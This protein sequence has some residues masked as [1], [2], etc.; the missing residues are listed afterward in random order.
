MSDPN[1]EFHA[2]P[3]PPIQTEP[4]RQRPTWLMWTGIALFVIGLLIVGLGL[5]GVLPGMA[6][7]GGSV[8]ALGILFFAFSFMRLP[9]IP[10]APPRMSTVQTL[11]GIF[12]EPTRVFRNLRA[13][14]QWLAAIFIAG[15]LSGAYINTFHYRLTPDRVVGFKWDAIE[16]GPFKPP[17]EQLAQQRQTELDVQKSTAGKI[18]NVISSVVGSFFMMAFVAA[19]C[20]LGVIAFGGRMHYWQAF[21]VVAYVQF[22]FTVI[23][24]GISFLVLFLKAPEDVHPILGQQT[25]VYDNLGLL[26]SSKEHPVLYVIMAAIGV[27]SFYRLWLTATGLREGGYK[28]SSTAGWGVSI[29]LFIL[30]LLLGIAL[31]AF[32]PSFLG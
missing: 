22:P 10:D 23:E 26:V 13:H 27:L 32:F 1:Q 5:L 7:S 6:S 24:K 15:I 3:P 18:G 20:L 2:P 16:Q 8:C 21:S 25:L 30:F 9:A 14:P 12:F 4:E 28:V 17:P 11:V 31:A 19:L 29:T